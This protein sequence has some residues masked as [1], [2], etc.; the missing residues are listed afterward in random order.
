MDPD[1]WVFAIAL[2]PVLG[3]GGVL[4]D[5]LLRDAP[6]RG[7]RPDLGTPRPVRT[8]PPG[9]RS[10]VVLVDGRRVFGTPTAVAWRLGS[11]VLTDAAARRRLA[12]LRRSGAVQAWIDDGMF[13]IASEDGR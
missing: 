10:C 11:P 4:V 7:K 12:V 2:V 6:R 13:P 1:P 8:P 9:R 5:L 3:L